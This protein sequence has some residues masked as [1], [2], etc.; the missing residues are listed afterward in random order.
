[1]I[2]Y[3]LER[4][5]FPESP[6]EIFERCVRN[7]TRSPDK[8]AKLLPCKEL[9]K[10]DADRYEAVI[11]VGEIFPKPELPENVSIKNMCDV[12]DVKFSKSGNKLRKE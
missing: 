11:R 10:R 2:V 4:P 3:T 1:M 6:E 5:T 9:V 12:Y 8:V 7:Y